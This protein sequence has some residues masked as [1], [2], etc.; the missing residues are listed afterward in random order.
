MTG[1]MIGHSVEQAFGKGRLSVRQISHYL[2]YV[3][4]ASAILFAL[5]SFVTSMTLADILGW[6]AK[7]F[8]VSFSIFYLALVLVSAYALRKLHLLAAGSSQSL[9]LW[10]QIGLQAANGVSTLALTYTLLGISL[11]IGSLSEQSLTPENVNNVISILT[12][13]FSMAFMTTVVG[14]PTATAIRA[15][16]NIIYVK[17]QQSA[18]QSDQNAVKQASMALVTPE[19]IS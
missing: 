10:H 11:G 19:E 9:N 14:L 16:L 18:G 15:W 2:L 1:S 12:S 7:Y 17:R 4:G 8:G 3:C 13:Q 5:L 6:I